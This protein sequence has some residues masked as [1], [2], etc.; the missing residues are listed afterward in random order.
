MAPAEVTQKIRADAQAQA[1]AANGFQGDP[2][3]P[4]G[5]YFGYLASASATTGLALRAPDPPPAAP[6]PPAAS[7]SRPA[8]TCTTKRIV[9]RHR[10]VVTRHTRAGK[11]YRTVRI[12]RHVRMQRVCR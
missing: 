7:P 2:L 12:H 5:R 10:H 4:L 11:R 1:T 6:A 8:H 9:R 3:H